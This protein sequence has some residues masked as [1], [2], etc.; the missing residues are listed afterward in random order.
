MNGSLTTTELKNHIHTHWAG[1]A[2]TQKGLVLHLCV[3]DK[4]WGASL[5]LV[6]LS[7]LSTGCEPR[8][9]RCDSQSGHMPGLRARSSVGTVLEASTYRCF[10]L[11]L[12][13][14]PSL[15]EIKIK[16]LKKKFRSY[17]L[18]SR[19]PSPTPGPTP[20]QGSIARKLSPHNYWLQKPV[21]IESVEETS[22]VLSS[23]S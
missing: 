15:K 21:G 12:S 3:V 19:S 20:A 2:E 10:P 8:G 4:N 14:S 16:I 17:I 18:G 13:P 11:F 7:G 22:G 5:G 6:W 23:S 9:C 1:G